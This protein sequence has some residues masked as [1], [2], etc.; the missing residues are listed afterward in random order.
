[1]TLQKD[2]ENSEQKRLLDFADLTDAL[3]LEI[4]SGEGRLTHKYAGA[5]KRTVGLDPDRDALRVAQAD[6]PADMRSRVA[7]VC[8]S[9][10]NIPFTKETFDRAVLAWSL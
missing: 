4:G 2:P 5:S 6:C 7:W 1:M 10:T 8:A 9:A 3:V